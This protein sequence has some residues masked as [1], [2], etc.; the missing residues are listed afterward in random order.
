[1]SLLFVHKLS[2]YTM[3]EAEW[4][5]FLLSLIEG[6]DKN[7]VLFSILKQVSLLSVSERSV[8][9]S[10]DSQGFFIFIQKRVPEIEERL[11]L[12]TK[13]T[14]SIEVVVSTTQE[15]KMK[16]APLLSFEPSQEDVYRKA[17]LNGK[18]SFDNFAVS[19]SNQV[20][21]AA[22]QAVADNLS[23]AYNPLFLYGGVGVG[24]THLAQA[25]ASK[26]LG[27]DPQKRVVFSP[28]EQFTNELIESIREKNTA[29]FRKRYRHLNL[30]IVD[31]I[32]FIAG[33][34]T[35]QEEFFHTFNAVVSGGG[36]II[37]TSDRPPQDIKNLEDRLRSRFAGGLTVDVQPPDFELRTAILL[38]KAKEKGVELGIDLARIIA[39]QV[40][41]SRSLE[42]TLLSIYARTLGREEKITLTVVESFFHTESEVRPKIRITPHEILNVV[43]S[44][45]NIKQSQL[46]SPIRSESLSLPRQVT[47]FL[48][49]RELNMK[50]QEIANLLKRRDHTTIMHGV[51]KINKMLVK[52]DFFKKEVDRIIQT[53]H[54]ST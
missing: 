24:K 54:L 14:L 30:L 7:P 13:K 39:E 45:Y 22:A 38:I 40:S 18:Y 19:G 26:I 25:V 11:S 23:K 34:N 4:N 8:V 29:K 31:D 9:L 15:K 27:D 21:Y 5:Q 36:Q 52:D 16:E 53:L 44:Y 10:T 42:G 32:Q 33:K 1:M 17:G 3:S 20:A 35:V 28:G 41:D 12:F 6:A 46:K 47:M 2:T 37:F 48:L 43:C 50:H 51:E 49:R